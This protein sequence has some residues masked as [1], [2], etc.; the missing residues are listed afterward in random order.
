MT[1]PVLYTQ[2]IF[3]ADISLCFVLTLSTLSLRALS[4]LLIYVLKFL[5]YNSSIPAMSDSDAV[6]SLQIVF[7]TFWYALYIFFN[8]K[9]QCTVYKE[10]L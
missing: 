3:E 9:I 8:G 4:I 5:V 10:L 6:L 2:G 1:K 7:S